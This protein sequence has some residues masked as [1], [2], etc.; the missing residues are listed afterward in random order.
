MGIPLAHRRKVIEAHPGVHKSPGTLA[1]LSK[2]ISTSTDSDRFMYDAAI[3][4]FQRMRG[5][6][7]DP[8]EEVKL[9]VGMVNKNKLGQ[10]TRCVYLATAEPWP[11][12]SGFAKVD[13]FIGEVGNLPINP[14]FKKFLTTICPPATLTNGTENANTDGVCG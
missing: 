13:I 4:H 9:E 8:S 14:E 10:K 12:V 2:L 3:F 7:C 1:I 11:K 5:Q 6:N